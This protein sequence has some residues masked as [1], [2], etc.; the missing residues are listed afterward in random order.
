[1]AVDEPQS[2]T[3][4]ETAPAR[5]EF[6]IKL[7]LATAGHRQAKSLMSRIAGLASQA[8][9]RLVRPIKKILPVQEH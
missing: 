1:M 2:P 5:C 3:V 7:N 4:F 8:A 9:T 6:I